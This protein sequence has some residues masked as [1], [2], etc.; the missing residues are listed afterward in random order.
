MASAPRRAVITR[1]Q[2]RGSGRTSYKMA[3]GRDAIQP[4]CEFGE[5]VMF[6]PPKTNALAKASKWQDK[7]EFGKHLGSVLSSNEPIIGM[8]T[9]VLTA[10]DFNRL[11]ADERWSRD[12]AAKVQGTPREPKPASGEHKIPSFVP[13]HVKG[14]ANAAKDPESSEPP[15][16]PDMI[17]AVPTTFKIKKADNMEHRAT[18]RCLGCFAVLADAAAKK[19]SDSRWQ[20]MEEL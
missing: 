9:G 10:T 14:T 19:H 6:S 2:V 18:E 1:Y 3:K 4:V 5:M 8:S 17:P 16:G 20:R 13:W 12:F 15:S 11:P 7:K